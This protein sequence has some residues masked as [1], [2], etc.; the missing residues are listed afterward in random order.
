MI[1]LICDQNSQLQSHHFLTMF[2]CQSKTCKEKTDIFTQYWVNLFYNSK[3]PCKSSVNLCRLCVQVLGPKKLMFYTEVPFMMLMKRNMNR[4]HAGS[5]QMIYYYQLTDHRADSSFRHSDM[6]AVC[7][8][9]P[10]ARPRGTPEKQQKVSI[11]RHKRLKTW[12]R[13]MYLTV[14]L[15]ADHK[16]NTV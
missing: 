16:V 7:C 5:Q 2:R 1:N 4:F 10:V 9:P 12:S 11:L 13:Y 15:H 8:A 3:V 14:N 6:D